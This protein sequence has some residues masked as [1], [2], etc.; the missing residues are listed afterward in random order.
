MMSDYTGQSELKGVGGWLGIFVVILS[1]ISPIRI[2]I[3]TYKILQIDPVGASQLGTKWQ[4][5]KIST[6][7]LSLLTIAALLY[8]AYRLVRVHNRSTVP[9]VIKGL[10]AVA[11]I[12]VVLD[13]IVASILWP[14]NITEGYDAAYFIPIFQSLMF[15]TIWSLYLTKSRRVANTFVDDETDAHRIFG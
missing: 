1:I 15:T 11:V 10:W 12:P 7:S 4:I 3:E 14:D 13:F 8:F 2:V 5:Y 6:W 9:L